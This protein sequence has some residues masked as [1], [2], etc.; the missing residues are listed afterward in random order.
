MCHH[1]VWLVGRYQCGQQTCC[2]Y[3]HRWTSCQKVPLKFW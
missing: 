1:A 2:L 3:Y